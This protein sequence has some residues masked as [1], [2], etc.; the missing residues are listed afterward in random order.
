MEVVDRS[1]DV[2]LRCGESYMND[3]EISF[4]LV[5]SLMKLAGKE[6]SKKHNEIK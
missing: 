6:M 3:P 5:S 4:M 2:L 1:V